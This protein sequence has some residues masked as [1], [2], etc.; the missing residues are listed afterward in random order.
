MKSNITVS[1]IFH[2][3]LS[4]LSWTIAQSASEIGLFLTGVRQPQATVI[5]RGGRYIFEL[6]GSNAI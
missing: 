3:F 2:V 6:P 1:N 4:L 5:D